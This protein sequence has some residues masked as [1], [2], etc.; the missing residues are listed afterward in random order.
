MSDIRHFES[1]FAYTDYVFLSCGVN[2][3]SRYGW[4]AHKLFEYFS[5]LMHCYR[6]K[7]P[8]TVFVYN[9]ILTTKYQWLNI[10]INKLNIDIFNL[11]LED[12][13]CNLWFLDTHHVALTSARNGL[14]IL[15][16]GFR[17]KRAN[18]VHITY[19]AS[20]VIRKVIFEC[21]QN[22]IQGNS[23]TPIAT[24][25]LRAQFTRVAANARR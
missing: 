23:S 2:D 12:Y 1:E 24:W 9:S 10:E 14:L 22:L 17:S 4:S 18:G 20:N 7:Y 11:S 8:N 3:I 13:R 19:W 5:E 25:P 6:K 15:E 16:E 21:L